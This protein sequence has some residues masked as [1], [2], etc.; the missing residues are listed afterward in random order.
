MRIVVNAGHTKLGVGTGAVG[1]LTE[2]VETRKIAYELMKQLV[3][4]NYEVIPAVFDKS[5]NNLKAAV[6][7]SNENS[8]DLFISIHLN[9][10]GGHGCEAYTWKGKQSKRALNI[11]KNLAK[12]GYTNRGVKDG[13]G[14]YL[15]KNTKCE[16]I[17]IETCFVD[18]ASDVNLLKTNG[19]EQI[20][21]AIKESL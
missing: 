15:I 3:D 2:S 17:L 21:K 11:C 10:G 1:I 16:A 12:L 9:A 8:A 13:S 20:A 19:Y 6:N 14:L 7:L 5:N 18:N 4:T